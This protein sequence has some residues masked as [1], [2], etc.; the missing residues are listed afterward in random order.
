MPPINP[1]CSRCKSAPKHITPAGNRRH[2][3]LPCM[4]EMKRIARNKP[5]PDVIPICPC[6]KHP[7]HVTANGKLAWY[8]NAC[9]IERQRA[10]RAKKA[11]T[12]TPRTV[13]RDCVDCGAPRHVNSSG[14]RFSYC[15]DCKRKRDTARAAAKL[16]RSA[17]PRSNDRVQT[18]KPKCADVVERRRR[19]ALIRE[20][21]TLAIYRLYKKQIEKGTLNG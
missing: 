12:V 18:S 13:K 17:T 5:A 1:N 2:Y 6:D 9:L 21:H 8:C 20:A 3:C 7:R 14:T 16:G 15:I 19:L 4:S 11:K 10:Q